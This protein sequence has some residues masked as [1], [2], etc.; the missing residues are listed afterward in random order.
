[1]SLA[2]VFCERG[3]VW[4]LCGPDYGNFKE[5]HGLRYHARILVMLLCLISNVNDVEVHCTVRSSWCGIVRLFWSTVGQHGLQSR[6][7]SRLYWSIDKAP[8]WLYDIEYSTLDL[9]LWLDWPGSKCIWVQSKEVNKTIGRFTSSM[10]TQ[11]IQC[12]CATFNK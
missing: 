9:Y 6:C 4:N 1:M 8:F 2:Y 3:V 10:A 5:C 7:W 12:L 11:S